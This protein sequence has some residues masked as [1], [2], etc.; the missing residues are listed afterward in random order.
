MIE[1]I[2]KGCCHKCVVLMG[3]V[4]RQLQAHSYHLNDEVKIG[5]YMIFHE[6]IRKTPGLLMNQNSE[7]FIEMTDESGEI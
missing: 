3:V 2:Y 4:F 5:Y 1:Y 6:S 7:R